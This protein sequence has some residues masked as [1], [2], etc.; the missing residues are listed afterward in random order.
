MVGTASE[1][2]RQVVT[3]WVN[4]QISKVLA[5]VGTNVNRGQ[6][7]VLRGLRPSRMEI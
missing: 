1:T 5:A 2:N 7:V 6:A 3:M 4:L